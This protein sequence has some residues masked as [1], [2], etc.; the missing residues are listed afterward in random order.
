[1]VIEGIMS[2]FD[3]SNPTFVAH[4]YPELA[5]VQDS[6]VQ[7]DREK[8]VGIE[9]GGEVSEGRRMVS[10]SNAWKTK[11]L[12][13]GASD[14]EV[15]ASGRGLRAARLLGSLVDSIFSMVDCSSRICYD[16]VVG[17]VQREICASGP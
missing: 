6:R 16:D 7:S 8:T 1:M 15:V 17:I 10:A 5:T 13:T 12:R 3:N 9:G 4:E 14:C 11:E 2:T